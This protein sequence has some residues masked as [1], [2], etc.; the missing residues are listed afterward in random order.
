VLS[1]PSHDR[2]QAFGSEGSSLSG[3]P[4]SP[5]AE[6]PLAASP[7]LSVSLPVAESKEQ[8]KMKWLVKVQEL[9]RSLAQRLLAK[10]RGRQQE[11]WI[12]ELEERIV[13]N[14]IWSD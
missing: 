1:R 10:D 13:P 8:R 4:L 11:L 14:A 9:K 3:K 12:E 7:D 6:E 2:R 5:G